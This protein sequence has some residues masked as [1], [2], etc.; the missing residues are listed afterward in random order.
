MKKL[1]I[2]ALLLL[3]FTSCGKLL[4]PLYIHLPGTEWTYELNGVQAYVHFDHDGSA[5]VLQ[6]ELSTGYVQEN[7]GTYISDGHNAII[8]CPDGTTFK[9][10]RTFSHLKNSKNKNMSRI[11]LRHYDSIDGMLWA[12]VDKG[13]L[14][15]YFVPDGEHFFRASFVVTKYEEGVPLKWELETI[16]YTLS[17]YTFDCA[18]ETAWLF[19][20]LMLTDRRWHVYFPSQAAA[21]TSDLA[22]SLWYFAGGTANTPGLLVFDSGSSFV[23]IQVSSEIQFSYERGSYTSSGNSIVMTLNG[24]DDNCT[25]SNDSF[26]FMER[27]YQRLL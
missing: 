26:K 8:S 2:L 4:E 16:P 11:S 6:R 27:R 10:I 22:G 7:S 23:R 18:G 13:D 3:A 12:G 5:C 24:M 1:T 25:I 9:M 17:Q 15:V 19:S 20:D 21:G 14:Y